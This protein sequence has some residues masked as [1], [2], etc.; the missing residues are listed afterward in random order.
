MVHGYQAKFSIAVPKH[1]KVCH[2]WLI[3]FSLLVHIIQL[4]LFSS[5]YLPIAEKTEKTDKDRQRQTKT[6][7]ESEKTDNDRQRQTKTDKD[8]QRHKKTY[9]EVKDRQ[10][11]N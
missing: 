9:K 8:K 1:L 3:Q 4:S 7:K 6:D 2:V 10:G 5:E 11:Q